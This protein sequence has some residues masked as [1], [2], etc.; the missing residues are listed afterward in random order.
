M[1]PARSFRD[2]T[3]PGGSFARMISASAAATIATERHSIHAGQA[4]SSAKWPR[5]NVEGGYLKRTL[6]TRQARNQS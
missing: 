1:L 3:S 6:N 5:E 4:L 2:S